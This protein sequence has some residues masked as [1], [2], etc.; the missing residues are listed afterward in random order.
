MKIIS[1]RLLVFPALIAISTGQLFAQNGSVIGTILDQQ[2]GEELVGANVLVVGTKLGA[3]TDIEGKY[4]IK[5][6]P[7]GTYTM[8]ISFIGYSSKTISEV[9]VKSNEA[10][11]LNVTIASAIVE[12]EEVTVTAERVLATESALLS[13]RKKATSIGDAISAE[14]IKRAPDATSGDALKR[15]T[16]LSIVDNKFV[17]IRG[18]TDRYNNTTLNG[19]A[20]TSTEADKKGFSFDMLPSNLLENTIVV[21]SATPDLPG[22][23]TGGLVQLNTL[24]FPV[25]RTLKLS[26]SSSL[27]SVTHPRIS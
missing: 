3:T 24:D 12:A 26:L 2:T 21:K 17:Y 20:L 25:S 15:V 10:L 5:N 8:R 7:A 6:V 23:F 22:D 4:Q 19:A 18:I 9:N 11:T 27:N 1:M 14:Q 13:E 16:G